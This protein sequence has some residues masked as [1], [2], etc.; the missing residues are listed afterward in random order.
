M[1]YTLYESNRKSPLRREDLNLPPSP[2]KDMEDP[3]GYKADP[4]LAAAVNVALLLRQ[5]LLLTGEA[6]TGKT[7][8][9]YHIA[10]QFGLGQPLK[11]ETKSTTI[12]KDLFYN[13][14]TMGRF[15]AAQTGDGSNNSLDYITF[16]ALGTAILLANP[17]DTVKDLLP[18]GFLHDGPRRSVVLID[19]VEK[20]PRDFPNDILN[21]IREMYFRI[22]ELGN[23]KVAA[24]PD[25]QPIVILTSN[26]EKTLPDAFLRRCV[27][28]HIQFPEDP[29]R[30]ED[31]ITARLGKD[32]IPGHDW[33]RNALE[34]FR[35]LRQPE[36][37]LTKMP[38]TAELL[39]WLISLSRLAETNEVLVEEHWEASLAGLIKTKDDRAIALKL[40]Q[41]R[42]NRG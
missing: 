13:Y 30:L 1:K 19:E 18:E 8:L 26:S 17:L 39:D 33:A 5:P 36:S 20:A 10:W 25:M 7:Q 14:D 16:S 15:H 31:I 12:S 32:F 22:P 3:S 29:Q 11:L 34:F 40:W 9:A 41:S 37:Q 24:P 2:T 21:E 38:A 42:G 28:Y 27:Y 4:E 23:V 35:L 6:G